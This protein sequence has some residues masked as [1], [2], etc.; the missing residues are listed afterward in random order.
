MYFF[1][2]KVGKNSLFFLGG[3]AFLI[4]QSFHSRVLDMRF[5]QPTRRTRLVVYLSSYIQVALVELLLNITRSV[6]PIKIGL[7]TS[8]SI[9][10]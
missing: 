8:V 10:K 3:G 4:K 1:T 9:Q 6:P 2:N 5:L 7:T